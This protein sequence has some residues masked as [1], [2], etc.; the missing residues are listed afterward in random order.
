LFRDIVD[1]PDPAYRRNVGYYTVRLAESLGR[2]G[3][4]GA[5]CEVARQA[6]TLV[7]GLESARTAR[8]LGQFR[9]AVQPHAAVSLQAREFVEAYDDVYVANR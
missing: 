3:D 4:V 7:A 6:V 1:N 2:Q 8:F 9:R 5:A